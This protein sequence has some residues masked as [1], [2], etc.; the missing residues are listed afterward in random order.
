MADKN[1]EKGQELLKKNGSDEKEV[2]S[3]N[4]PD[5]YLSLYNTLKQFNVKS[6]TSFGIVDLFKSYDQDN[7]AKLEDI[8]RLAGVASNTRK[9]ILEKWA[10]L[11]GVK[12]ED[13]PDIIAKQRSREDEGEEEK[14]P[15][16]EEIEQKKEKKIEDVEKIVEDLNTKMLEQMKTQLAM[17]TLAQRLQAMGIDPKQY[18]LSIPMARKEEDDD[19]IEEFEFPPGSGKFLKMRTSK[20]AKL[21]TEWNATQINTKKKQEDEE[22]D[23]ID[24]FEYPPGSGKFLKM[25]TS[26]Y[27]KLITEWNAIHKQQ[28]Q[29]NEE[30][31][32]PWEDPVTHK[33]VQVPASQYH[34]Y[35]DISRKYQ[36]DPEKQ[37]LVKELNELKAKLEDKEKQDLYSYLDALQKK[38]KEIENKDELAETENSIKKLRAT[39]EHLGYTSQDKS[40]KDEALLKKIDLQTEVIKDGMDVVKEQAKKIGTVT[41]DL[42][43]AITPVI[44]Q[45]ASKVLQEQV[46][47]PIGQPTP[48]AQ[49]TLTPEQLVELEKQMDAEGKVQESIGEN[50]KMDDKNKKDIKVI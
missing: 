41:R 7:F 1:V 43:H 32:I 50:V 37:T 35:V 27:A 23:P 36:E 22:E 20:Y 11:L 46:Q 25:R 16:P 28:E 47:Q 44:Q 2:P 24:E 9:L 14:K 8:M 29:K 4:L 49:P 42:V 15:T 45:Q 17:A 12:P 33:I 30:N 13:V 31:M 10:N 19:P 48:P 40:V 18:G 34:Y 5:I 39:L 3:L 21:I 38:L 6:D 26:K